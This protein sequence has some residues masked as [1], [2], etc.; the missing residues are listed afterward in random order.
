M[1]GTGLKRN[2]HSWLPDPSAITQDH[3][4]YQS[5][6]N[7]DD[8]QIGSFIIKELQSVVILVSSVDE[9]APLLDGEANAKELDGAYT[10]PPYRLRST[11]SDGETNANGKSGKTILNRHVNEAFTIR[12]VS[13]T[14]QV[15]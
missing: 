9:L 3:D 11:Q 1:P 7:T 8:T 4:C 10:P 2:N 6:N 14:I 13:T 12:L 5:E 15:A